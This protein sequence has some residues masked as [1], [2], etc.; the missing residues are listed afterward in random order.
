MTALK[1]KTNDDV[2]QLLVDTP[3]ITADT[4]GTEGGWIASGASASDKKIFFLQLI[5]YLYN[6]VHTLLL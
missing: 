2:K 4:P 1:A 5:Y 3:G 6:I